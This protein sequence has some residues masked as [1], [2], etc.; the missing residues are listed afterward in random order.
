MVQVLPIS[1]TQ[2]Q[3]YRTIEISGAN[4]RWQHVVRAYEFSVRMDVVRVGS[5]LQAIQRS[6]PV[7][8]ARLEPGSARRLGLAAGNPDHPVP[9]S[10]R[11]LSGTNPA[12]VNAAASAYADQAF[13][14][15]RQAPY[16]VLQ[17][18]TGPDSSILVFVFNHIFNDGLGADIVVNDF[19]RLYN[20]DSPQ[21]HRAATFFDYIE[22]ERGLISAGDYDAAV[23]MIET[24]LGSARNSLEFGRSGAAAAPFRVSSLQLGSDQCAL[25]DAKTRHARITSPVIMLAAISAGLLEATGRQPAVAQVVHDLR[26]GRF[27]ETAG[28]FADYIFVRLPDEVPHFQDA[29]LEALRQS[30]EL[31]IDYALP[32]E[33]FAAKTRLPWCRERRANGLQCCEIVLNYFSA[34]KSPSRLSTAG[35][36]AGA[37]EVASRIPF[38]PYELDF[39]TE[40]SENFTGVILEAIAIRF[41]ESLDIRL[42]W[43]CGVVPEPRQRAVEDAIIRSLLSYVSTPGPGYLTG[44]PARPDT[45]LGCV[46]LAGEML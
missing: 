4:P 15:F 32:S 20:D 43:A 46:P 33:Y 14:L 23:K 29:Y 25:L 6:H 45:R 17:L 37:G 36:D 9:L 10:F 38:R 3:F 30:L 35:H 22:E 8:T 42:K 28:Q 31:A 18:D 13:D 24:G 26:R 19:L 40:F 21:D 34:N 41:R 16:R 1:L 12:T 2:Q 44:F 11:S 27:F 39:R 5:V 7:L